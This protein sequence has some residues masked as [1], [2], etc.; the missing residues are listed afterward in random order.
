MD[1][2]TAAPLTRSLVPVAITDQVNLRAT[3]GRD[4]D[5]GVGQCIG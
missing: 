1:T 3:A 4:A 5:S 2:V